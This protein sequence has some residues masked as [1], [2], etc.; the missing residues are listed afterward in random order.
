MSNNPV[1]TYN[2]GFFTTGTNSE[3]SILLARMVTQVAKEKNINLINFLGG[4][5]NP[6]FTFSQYKY[7]YQCNV[8][9]N[10]ANTP[11]LDGIILASGVLASFLDSTDFYNFYSQFKSIPIVSLGVNLP[12]LPSAYTDNKSVF[13]ELVSHLIQVHNRKK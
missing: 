9:F 8:A 10:F 2:I 12:D 7:Q 4:S 6:N 3:Y 5:L 11:K 13:H 1:P